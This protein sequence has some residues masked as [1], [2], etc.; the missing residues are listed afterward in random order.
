[1]RSSVLGLLLLTALFNASNALSA[2]P[3]YGNE[4]RKKGFYWHEPPPEEKPKEKPQT[5]TTPKPQ[6]LSPKNQETIVLDTA[7]LR[8]N[9]E[10]LRDT[11]IESPNDTN[12]A[13]FA[14]AQR[15][16]LDYSTR[17][18][19]RM[20]EYLQKDPVLD[21][22]NRRPTAAVGLH[23]FEAARLKNERNVLKKINDNAHIWFF[24]S[25]TCPYCLKQVPILKE[26]RHRYGTNILAVSMD[27]GTLPGLEQFDTVVDVNAT[28]TNR[29]GVSATPTMFLVS[30]Q[31]EY[32]YPLAVGLE[33]LDRVVDR[34]M[35]AARETNIIDD[36]TFNETKHV[37]EIN[38]FDNSK[39]VIEADKGRI[40][41]DPEY[42][43]EL[44]RAKLL[45]DR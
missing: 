25:S 38:I 42:L 24:Y 45:S 13:N 26:L 20:T 39:D 19:T 15:L 29:L 18:S 6:P 37:K 36:E 32:F 4:N 3:F 30:N 21:E 1:M 23:A 2:D 14:Y 11:A 9:I 44:L 33:S 41:N 7:W 34:L 27:G 8:E 40:E 17:F 43:S 5:P 31:K 16:T 35:L 12:L 10:R 28:M 22:E